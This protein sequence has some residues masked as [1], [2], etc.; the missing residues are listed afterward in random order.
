MKIN[1]PVDSVSGEALHSAVK[2]VF[3]MHPQVLE[4]EIGK[5]YV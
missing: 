3:C 4:R 1:Q 5:F 2:I